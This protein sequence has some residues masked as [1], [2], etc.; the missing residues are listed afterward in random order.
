M[1]MLV[2]PTVIW[3]MCLMTWRKKM[4]S[5]LL[6]NSRSTTAVTK[7]RKVETWT[8]ILNLLTSVFADKT[9]RVGENVQP[10]TFLWMILAFKLT[11]RKSFPTSPHSLHFAFGVKS[12]H[13]PSWITSWSKP[14]CM[15][16][17]TAIFLL[18]RLAAKIFRPSLASFFCWAII[19]F[20]KNTIIGRTV[21]TSA[22]QL[23][24]RQWA[25]Q[26]FATS[27]ATFTLRTTTTWSKAT[28]LRRLLQFT[29]VLTP[30]LPSLE[31]STKICRLM[32]RWGHTLGATVQRCSIV[33]SL[34]AS[35]TRSGAFPVRRAIRRLQVYKGKEATSSNEPL[36][37]RVVNHM[38]E[39][40]RENSDV[41]KH[42]FFFDNFF[43]SH[44]LLSDLA[45]EKVK[46]TGTVRENRTW[47]ANRDLMSTKVMKKS[48]RGTIDFCC[49]GTVFM[50]KWNDNSVI[51]VASNC[52][53]HSPVHE[54]WRPVKGQ[55]VNNV[56][57]PHLIH[58]YNQ[59]MGGVDLMDRMVASYRPSIR[60]KKRYWPLFTN[61]LNVTVV[62]DPLQD[63][64]VADVTSRLPT[65]ECNLFAEDVHGQSFASS[66]W[67]AGQ[68]RDDVGFDGEDHKKVVASQGRCKVC[69]NIAV[70][71][72]QSPTCGCIMT[73][74]Q[75][76]MSP[77]TC[78]VD[79]LN[80][81]LKS[82]PFSAQCIKQNTPTNL[83]LTQTKQISSELVCGNSFVKILCTYFFLYKFGSLATNVTAWEHS[84]ILESVDQ[85]EL[86]FCKGLLF[87]N[88][89]KCKEFQRN[90]KR[91]SCTG[92]KKVNRKT[93]FLVP[94]WLFWIKKK[95]KTKTD[96]R[97]PSSGISSPNYHNRL[98][99]GHIF[100]E[101]AKKN[102]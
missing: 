94:W 53:T 32:N 31:C 71:C 60:G 52:Q 2:M 45:S 17:A 21:K 25:G 38:V 68:P 23:F 101:T 89:S 69:K 4:V 93:P 37:T 90:W 62:V 34:S 64:W 44:K 79:S 54:V 75:N 42:H 26:V 30:P 92:G 16:T 100:M 3:R 87:A 28:K 22:S 1:V 81:F 57:Q 48:T 85:I 102:A 80:N 84:C 11:L 35:G 55:P 91:F 73:A 20:P 15:Q 19:I 58:A 76:A 70:T 98:H 78:A 10:S 18:F 6:K 12:S 82:W 63:R 77:T 40:V 49:D 95:C 83:C 29:P 97:T 9:F 41:A 27:S 8:L 7:S 59:G 96:A 88:S 67:T 65:G 14:T 51:T 66:R 46:A 99:L 56:Q 61:A 33:E 43:T 24:Q 86:K 74:S 72:V 50:C 13:L 5:R 47:G 39:V 36:G